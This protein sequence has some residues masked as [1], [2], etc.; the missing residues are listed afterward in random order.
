[1][2]GENQDI[3][4]RNM[5]L[6]K[7]STTISQKL[8]E[9]EVHL[10]AIISPKYKKEI[11]RELF[12]KNAVIEKLKQKIHNY[13]K[14]TRDLTIKYCKLEELLNKTQEVSQIKLISFSN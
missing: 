11:D 14:T 2:L 4:H 5:E 9:N 7:Y 1:M 3:K 12:D 10:Q 13:E 8:Q 6:N